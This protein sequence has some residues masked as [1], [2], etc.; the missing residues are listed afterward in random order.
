M[1]WDDWLTYR[2]LDKKHLPYAGGFKDQPHLCM[3]VIMLLDGLFEK[4]LSQIDGAVDSNAA[5]SQEQL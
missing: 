5:P 2:A 3:Q 4:I 1:Y